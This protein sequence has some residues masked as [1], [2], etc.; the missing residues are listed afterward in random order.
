MLGNPRQSVGGDKIIITAKHVR[1]LEEDNI[2]GQDDCD[3]P[4]Q[5]QT[6]WAEAVA[7]GDDL[8]SLDVGLDDT[9]EWCG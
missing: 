7:K 1:H 3:K 9:R 8:A 5:G 4:F 2:L 6:V